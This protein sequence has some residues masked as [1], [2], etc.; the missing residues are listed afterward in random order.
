M[1]LVP[2][3]LHYPYGTPS[4]F[5]ANCGII[6]GNTEST[7]PREDTRPSTRANTNGLPSVRAHSSQ[8]CRKRRITVSKASKVFS[9]PQQQHCAVSQPVGVKVRGLQTLTVPE[10]QPYLAET[11]RPSLLGRFYRPK[12]A[13]C[14]LSMKLNLTEEES[15]WKLGDTSDCGLGS[16]QS[17]APVP[18]KAIKLSD[19]PVGDITDVAASPGS[20]RSD[21]NPSTNFIHQH[22]NKEWTD[23]VQHQ[24]KNSC[25]KWEEV[26]KPLAYVLPQ[27][28]GRNST[29]TPLSISPVLKSGQTK[30]FCV[31]T[32]SP[33]LPQLNFEQD[34]L[35]LT[36]DDPDLLVRSKR[37]LQ[38]AFLK[39]HRNLQKK[40]NAFKLD[41]ELSGTTVTIVVYLREQN[42]LFV[43]HVGNSRAVLCKFN[44]GGGG[45]R[46]VDL[47][48]DHTPTNQKELR[49]IVKAGG[50]VKALAGDGFHRI[51]LTDGCLPGLAVARSIG[52]TLAGGIG[53]IALPEIKGKSSSPPF[54]S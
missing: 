1:R 4:P 36:T 7:E 8:A 32:I 18:S 20:T 45:V 17:S 9:S 10:S 2:L 38:D 54:P 25:S 11:V 19:P 49:R 51:F 6:A 23:P 29:P 42:K 39:A 30:S 27:S 22:V 5:Y 37:V 3:T 35:R 15:P 26:P 44:R 12:N 16:K 33:D 43:A 47:T 41:S 50:Q 24:C 48:V 31:S 14:E 28:L 13:A 53:V 40:C 52:D 46:A 21:G 34:L